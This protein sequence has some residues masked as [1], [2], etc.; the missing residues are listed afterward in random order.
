MRGDRRRLSEKL[1]LNLETQVLSR[2]AALVP[3]SLIQLMWGQPLSQGTVHAPGFALHV[4]PNRQGT[5][6]PQDAL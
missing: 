1:E 5:R 6:K 3:T 4:C 2:A